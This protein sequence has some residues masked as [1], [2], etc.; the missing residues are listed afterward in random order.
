MSRHILYD[1]FIDV[2]DI[3]IKYILFII[4]V[5]MTL[6]TIHSK[7]AVFVGLGLP[8]LGNS[9]TSVVVAE[10]SSQGHGH[11]AGRPDAVGRV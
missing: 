11:V 9:A 10:S 8:D 3:H 4:H 7:T 2:P 5:F 1:Q 6:M